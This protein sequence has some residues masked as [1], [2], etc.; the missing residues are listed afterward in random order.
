MIMVFSPIVL[1]FSLLIFLQ[2]YKNP[3]YIADRVGING[4]KFKMYKLR[5]MI[6][7]ADKSGVD[8]T[9]ANDIRI[10]AI[11]KIIRRYKLDELVQF[12][13]VLKGDM[14]IVGPRPNVK[15]ETDL[16][17]KEEQI[18]LH[19]KPGIT[20]FSSIVF[21]D[22]GEILRGSSDPDLDYN[23]LIRPGK[24]YLGMEY[25]KNRNLNIDFKIC[26]Y[27]AYSIFSRRLALKKIEDL[28]MKL[29]AGDMVIKIA[30]RQFPLERMPPPG[31]D[32]LVL[33]RDI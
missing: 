9:A 33:S 18:L 23:Q 31:S 10:T 30:S 24:S 20:D 27:T 28:L 4:K 6:F 12:V 26:L 19:V 17:T 3:F 8:S 7:A 22:E 21:S 2:D 14:S 29:D 1:I 15:R 5:S 25:I 32:E 13:N 11:G 16:Y